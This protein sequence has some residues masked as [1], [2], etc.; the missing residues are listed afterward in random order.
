MDAYCFGVRLPSI[1]SNFEKPSSFKSQ[2]LVSAAHMKHLAASYS[3][4]AAANIQCQISPGSRKRPED[5][6]SVAWIGVP[7][8]AALEKWQRPICLQIRTGFWLDADGLSATI[9]RDMDHSHFFISET[10]IGRLCKIIVHFS[11]FR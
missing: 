5:I 4:A 6:G 11:L 9:W 3:C 7:V 1:P 8:N 2:K 10:I